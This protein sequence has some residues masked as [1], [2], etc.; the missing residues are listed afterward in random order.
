MIRMINTSQLAEKCEQPESLTCTLLQLK[1][2]VTQRHGVLVKEGCTILL[3]LSGE[4]GFSNHPL[5]YH[6]MG[7]A[8]PHHLTKPDYGGLFLSG[9]EN[10]PDR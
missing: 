1:L 6:L 2:T 3:C 8:V 4:P 7:I 10:E 9:G 5:W